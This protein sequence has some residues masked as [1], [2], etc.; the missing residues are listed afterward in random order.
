MEP[1]AR[2]PSGNPPLTRSTGSIDRAGLYWSMVG[3]VVVGVAG[4]TLNLVITDQYGSSI[5]GQ[6]N[7]LLAIF[8]I[9]GQLGSVGMQS[10]LLFHTPRARSIDHATGPVLAAALKVNLVSSAVCVAAIVGGA[11]LVLGEVGNEAY[12]TG[13]RAIALGLFLYPI[14]KTLLAHI[15]GL[16][17]ITLFAIIFASRYVLLVAMVAGLAL[18]GADGST[19]P[20]AVTGAELVLTLVLVA[21]QLGELRRARHAVREPELTSR[22][23]R[24]GIRGMSGGL[25]LDLNTRVDVLILGGIAGSGAVGRYSIASIFAEG[26]YQLAM[27]SRYSFDPVVAGL[28]VEHRIDELRHLVHRSMRRVYLLVVPVGVVTILVYPLST[29]FLFG[30]DLADDTWQLYALLATGVVLTAGYIPFTNLL[31]QTGDPTRHSL[32]LA[33]VSTTNIVLN[34]LLVP[35]LGAT[36]SAIGTAVAQVALIPYLRRLSRPR[37]GFAP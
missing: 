23:V 36:G 18:L 22:L 9:G 1:D 14:N 24:F 28:F 35:F 30:A 26:L 34:L 6:F 25:L 8:L 32:L 31:Q 10:A 33:L 12:R 21:T 15:N 4:L 19:L 2:A 16:G 5:L 20:W 27:V 13:L 37:V 29:S 11:E 17:R 7:V 3:F